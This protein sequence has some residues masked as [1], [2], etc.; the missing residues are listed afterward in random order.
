M[1][2]KLKRIVKKSAFTFDIKRLYINI[3]TFLLF[4]L[5]TFVIHP[6]YKNILIIMGVFILLFKLLI[7]WAYGGERLQKITIIK[8]YKEFLA[9]LILVFF[10]FPDLYYLTKDYGILNTTIYTLLFVVTCFVGLE[11]KNTETPT[12]K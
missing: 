6:A 11:E 3:F 10:L 8:K 2:N 1:I 9:L 4:V 12:F 5:V 7:L